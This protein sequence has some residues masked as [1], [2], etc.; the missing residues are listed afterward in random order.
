MSSFDTQVTPIKGLVE[1]T[2]TLMRKKDH[3][4]VIKSV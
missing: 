4:I 3:L 1:Q 2:F